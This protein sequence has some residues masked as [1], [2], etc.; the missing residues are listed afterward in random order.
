M[1]RRRR[2]GP[3]PGVERKGTGDLSLP[4]YAATARRVDFLRTTQPVRHCPP[5]PERAADWVV[6]E[7]PAAVDAFLRQTSMT[8]NRASGSYRRR[9]VASIRS[10][11]NEGSGPGSPGDQTTTESG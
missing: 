7:V 10:I 11:L 2:H 8:P 6:T 9:I 5:T 4:L 3:P 1:M